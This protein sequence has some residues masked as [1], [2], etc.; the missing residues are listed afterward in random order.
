MGKSGSPADGRIE[1]LGRGDNYTRCYRTRIGPR[2]QGRRFKTM[3]KS[4]VPFNQSYLGLNWSKPWSPLASWDIREFYSQK[5]LISPVGTVY[6][7]CTVNGRVYWQDEVNYYW[8]GVI[9]RLSDMRQQALTGV[10][11]NTI[12]SACSRI[13]LYRDVFWGTTLTPGRQ[14]WVRAGYY[15]NFSYAQGQNLAQFDASGP[16]SGG[17]D[18]WFGENSE[19]RPRNT[20][21]AVGMPW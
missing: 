3:E 8:Y 18:G 17:L 11:T 19:S 10:P 14:A 5:E 16:Y 6:G 15:G 1:V 2:S 12:E 13:A 4:Y 9:T 21:I 20:F 7:T